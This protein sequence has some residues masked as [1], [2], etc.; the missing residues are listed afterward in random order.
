MIYDV[1]QGILC[2]MQR[3]LLHPISPIIKEG[4][5]IQYNKKPR[6]IKPGLYFLPTLLIAKHYVRLVEGLSTISPGAELL[7]RQDIT[8]YLLSR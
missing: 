3:S 8:T 6:C 7:R 4:E 1:A 5:H 2:L